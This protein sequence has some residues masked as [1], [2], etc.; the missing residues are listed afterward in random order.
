MLKECIQG[1]SPEAVAYALMLQVFAGKGY[2]YA[3]HTKL[4]VSETEVLETYGRCL[5]AVKGRTPL[6]K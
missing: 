2:I 5:D 4:D 6:P 1:D 3:G